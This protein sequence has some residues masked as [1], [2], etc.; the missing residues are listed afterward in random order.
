MPSSP[1]LP[2]DAVRE[3]LDRILASPTFQ[4]ADRLSRFLRYVT[5]QT[6]DGRSGGIKEFS[7][8]L[9]VFERGSGFDPRADSVV[10]VEAR[11]LREKLR[12]YY[13]G[14]GAADPIVIAMPKGGY[15]PEFHIAGALA[16]EHHP[17]WRGS[18]VLW[19]VAAAMLAVPLGWLAI[20]AARSG[21]LSGGQAVVVLPL[22]NL[23]GVAA[24]NFFCH[25]L[26][27]EIASRL[28]GGGIAVLTRGPGGPLEAGA[29]LREFAARNQARLALEGSANFEGDRLHA[30]VMLVDLKS[31]N[32]L[33]VASYDQRITD[34]L[35]S[36]RELSQVIAQQ[37]QAE[38]RKQRKPL[39]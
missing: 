32:D 31:F 16:E 23:S 20:S 10:R 18:M 8:G 6:L 2:D 29:D 33:W 7:I 21:G 13:D 35:A 12:E 17:S 11:R 14:P 28:S 15:V 30:T 26:A 19:I 36:V 9:E 4:T 5:D 37:A 39:F 1:S 34:R 24:N 22:E 38:I 27:D 25:A 3:Q